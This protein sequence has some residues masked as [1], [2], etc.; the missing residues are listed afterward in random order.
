MS[1]RSLLLDALYRPPGLA[2]AGPGVRIKF[3]RR[4]RGRGSIELGARVRV[5]AHA[6]IEALQR[7]GDQEFHPRI[8]LA[9]E[10]VVGRHATIT[11]I[12]SVRIGSGSLLSE[13]VYISDHGHAVEGDDPR[14]LAA[15]PL[16][17]GGAVQIGAQCFVGF[18]ACILPGVTL[19]DR[20][21]VG[22]HAVVTHSF[23]AG[24]VVAGC[25]ARLLRRAGEAP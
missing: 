24:S 5:D 15:R 7:Y 25:P 9:D 16:R 6:W 22:A 19:G 21:V 20:C 4:L 3:P 14:P 8:V 1:L 2:A 10:V 18:R 17:P 12:E 23:P 11:A 13:G